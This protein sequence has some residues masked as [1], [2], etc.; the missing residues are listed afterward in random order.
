ML[1]ALIRRYDDA[2]RSGATTV[3]NW[4]SGARREFLHVDDV[5]DAC[6]FLLEHHDGASTSTSA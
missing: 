2:V 1:P 6:L 3:T 5:A 4:G